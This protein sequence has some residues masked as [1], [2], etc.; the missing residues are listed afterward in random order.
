METLKIKNQ[1]YR[2]EAKK[3]LIYGGARYKTICEV[4]R[5]LYDQ[6]HNKKGKWKDKMVE[7]MVDGIIMGKS[8]HS[9]LKYYQRKY[10]DK[11]GKKGKNLEYLVGA[12]A[13][14]RRRA[15]REIR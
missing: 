7:L 9:R 3:Q 6:I 4:F 10:N 8:I 11:T 15:K 14:K 1:E 12:I 5:L 13:R 2:K